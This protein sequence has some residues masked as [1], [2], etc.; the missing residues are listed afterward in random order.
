MKRIRLAKR[1]FWNGS[2]K[3]LTLVVNHAIRTLH[4]TSFS[5]D[6]C[7][8]TVLKTFTRRKV[9]LL[10]NNSLTNN[11]LYFT[12]FILDKP[13]TSSELSTTLAMISYSDSISKGILTSWDI[14]LIRKISYFY[15]YLNFVFHNLS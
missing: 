10:T 5:I 15:I 11:F 7:T 6:Y 1:E 12:C 4:R 2:F 13:A 9:R 8:R 3:A 14:R